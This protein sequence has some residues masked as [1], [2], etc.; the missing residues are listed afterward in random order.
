MVRDYL[1]VVLMLPIIGIPISQDEQENFKMAQNYAHKIIKHGGLP[2]FLPVTIKVSL[3]PQ[4]ANSIDGLLLPGGVDIDPI[5]YGEQPLPMLGRIAPNTDN[6]EMNIIKEFLPLNKPIFGIC[7]GCQILNVALGGTLYQDL[8]SEYKGVF[9]H[10]Q[11]APRSYP[12]HTIMIDQGSRLFQLADN[13]QSVRV[14]T[15]H[16]QAVKELG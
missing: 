4:I 2:L 8:Q 14:N 15:I 9:Q 1:K 7:R 16:H 3:I 11:R 5:L 13:R 12:T 6:F 10:D